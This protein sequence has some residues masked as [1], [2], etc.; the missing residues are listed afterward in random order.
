[1]AKQTSFEQQGSVALIAKC[2]AHL[3]ITRNREKQSPLRKIN[4]TKLKMLQA[5][6]D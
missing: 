6:F 1:M 5:R 4:A 2:E 3:K